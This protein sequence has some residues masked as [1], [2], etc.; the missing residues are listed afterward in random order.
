MFLYSEMYNCPI[1]IWFEAENGIKVKNDLRM[2][3]R[4][5]LITMI[6]NLL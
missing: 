1:Q 6:I 4:M 3:R 2:S 5:I